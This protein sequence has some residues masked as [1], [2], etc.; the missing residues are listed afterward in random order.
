MGCALCVTAAL[1]GGFLGCGT[2]ARLSSP[3][4]EKIPEGFFSSSSGALKTIK[5]G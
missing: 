3:I 1:L 5:D 2:G 4:V